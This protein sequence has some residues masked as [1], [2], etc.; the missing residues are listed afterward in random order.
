MKPTRTRHVVLWLTVIAYM[1]TYM[2]RVVISNAAPKIE[3]ELNISHVTMGFV[4]SAF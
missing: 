4:M 2:D 1:I 3:E